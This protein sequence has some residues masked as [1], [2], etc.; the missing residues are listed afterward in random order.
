[1]AMS[2]QGFLEGIRMV[3][4]RDLHTS[5]VSWDLEASFEGFLRATARDF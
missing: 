2:L 5:G 4:L 3:T 1:M